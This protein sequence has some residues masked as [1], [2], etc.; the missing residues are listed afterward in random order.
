[1][2]NPNQNPPP[3]SPPPTD[4]I[5][6]VRS[7]PAT[8]HT[9]RKTSPSNDKGSLE[10]MVLVLFY[11]RMWPPTTCRNNFLQRSHHG[12][13]RQGPPQACL[14]LVL[15]PLHEAFYLFIYV[16]IK[17]PPRLSV[18]IRLDGTNQLRPAAKQCGYIYM[19]PLHAHI[20]QLL[21]DKVHTSYAVRACPT[22][23]SHTPHLRSEKSS[24]IPRQ[25]GHTC[26]HCPLV[27][28]SYRAKQ[29][30]TYLSSA[31]MSH[32]TLA[33]ASYRAK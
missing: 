30:H 18:L 28:T 15:E 11:R 13:R 8:C 25:C 21:S 24:H 10:G 32:L 5:T 26:S 22:A 17:I 29:G 20:H 1:M 19:F 7:T 27:D 33:H 23:H 2:C 9:K 12:R 3:S 31:G 16:Q 4:E 14:L 6:K